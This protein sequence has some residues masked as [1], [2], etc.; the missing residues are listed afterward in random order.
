M[1]AQV[2]VCLTAA[3]SDPSA[4]QVY[5]KMWIAH[6]FRDLLKQRFLDFLE[7]CRLDDVENL[8]N[9]PQEHD[10]MISTAVKRG[11]VRSC[12]VTVGADRRNTSFWLQVFG[13]NFRSPRITCTHDRKSILKRQQSVSVGGCERY[14]LY[15]IY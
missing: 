3:G 13:Q 2:M 4:P 6:T 8:L 10:L 7:L 12:S 14:F 11:R 1:C 15:T 9:F 5:L